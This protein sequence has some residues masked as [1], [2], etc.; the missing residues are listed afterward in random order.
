MD[1]LRRAERGRSLIEVL[2]AMC[3]LLVAVMATASLLHS[4]IIMNRLSSEGARATNFLLERLEEVRNTPFDQVVSKGE[5][6]AAQDSAASAKLASL[7][8]APAADSL[9]GATWSRRVVAVPA[10]DG[11]TSLKAV[12]VGVVWGV[13]EAQREVRLTTYV[14]QTGVNKTVWKPLQGFQ[15]Q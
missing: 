10:A 3:L 9:Q 15:N 2:F 1:H 11:R 12:E 13:G 5:G 8:L 7:G 6:M 4:S 14:A